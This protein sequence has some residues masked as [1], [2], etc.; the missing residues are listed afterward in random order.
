MTSITSSDCLENL[1]REAKKIAP[2][3]RSSSDSC[4]CV[5]HEV[6][7]TTR[8]LSL[9]E[10]KMQTS[11][12]STSPPTNSNGL[13]HFYTRLKRRFMTGKDYR[14]C[15]V[16]TH[17][18]ISIGFRNYKSFSSSTEEPT[19]QFPWPDFER[20]YDTI[21]LC[22]AKALPG[23]DDLSIEETDDEDN[24]TD[25][26][27]FQV[28]EIDDEIDLFEKCQRGKTFRRNAICNKLDKTQYNGQLDT[29]IQ[30]LMIE[31][32]MRTWT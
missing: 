32:L 19:K 3:E 14:T 21:P 31:K 5:S 15:S 27:N 22:L 17:R 6:T 30:Q 24:R 18:G 28:D 9:N 20:I 16:D 2:N 10:G 13:K 23:L 1:N 25:T 29:F 12:S 4:R 8:A 26:T 7:K 11:P